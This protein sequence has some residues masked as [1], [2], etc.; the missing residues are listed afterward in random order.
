MAAIACSNLHCVSN[1]PLRFVLRFVLPSADISLGGRGVDPGPLCRRAAPPPKNSILLKGCTCGSRL[2]IPQERI[3]ALIGPGGRNLQGIQKRTNARLDVS[4]DGTVL[5][6]GRDEA[7]T[8]A[9][10]RAAY[11]GSAK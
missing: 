9:A 3:G 6:L 4:D 5:V 8:R 1:A 11:S 2:R 7:S 10:V